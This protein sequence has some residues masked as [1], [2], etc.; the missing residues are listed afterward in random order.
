MDDKHGS[1]II[2]SVST[3]K[4]LPPW[5]IFL[6]MAITVETFSALK[7]VVSFDRLTSTV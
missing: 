4:L 5:N 2:L 3:E 6:K 7:N 1:P